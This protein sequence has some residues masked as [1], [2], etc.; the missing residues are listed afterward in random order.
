MLVRRGDIW[1]ADLGEQKGSIQGGIRPVL[2][3][4]NDMG[5]KYSPCVQVVPITSKNKR[6]LPTHFDL[7]RCDCGLPKNSVALIEQ[8]TTIN[9]SQ[10]VDKIGSVP[11]NSMERIEQCI[12]V[13]FGIPIMKRNN[14]A[15]AM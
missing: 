7:N 11:M 3:V 14:Y 2:I 12:M 5:N 13:S 4:Q 1:Y 6:F 10:L 8:N 15:V 9:K